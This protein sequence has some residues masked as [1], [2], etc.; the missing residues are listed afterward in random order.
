MG[1]S[2]AAD[3]F[4]RLG[5]SVVDT[6]A[7]ARQVVEPGQEALSEIHR[8]F[9]SEVLRPDGSL[10]RQA[11]A[12]RV[13]A[14]PDARRRLEAILHPRIR[15]IWQAQVAQWMKEGRPAGVVVIPLL[16][17]TA[18]QTQFDATICVA[19]SAATQLERLAP[20]GWPTD[21]VRQRIQAQMPI[22]QKIRLAD[23]LVWSEGSLEVHQQQLKIVLRHM[24]R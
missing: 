1:K 10:D 16:F 11:L 6:D 18:I 8:C 17:E 7:I 22:E 2:T 20:R 4:G 13:F 14:D 24:H 9:G 19:C 12:C 21:E 5:L 23:F 15:A 3:L